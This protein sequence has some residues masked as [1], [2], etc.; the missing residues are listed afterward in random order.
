MPV[1]FSPA[2]KNSECT[3]NKAGPALPC[4]NQ[5]LGTQNLPG[6]ILKKAPPLYKQ[7]I[8]P[9]K[10]NPHQC[11]RV[12]SVVC[13][14]Q[15]VT[16]PNRSWSFH[17][18]QYAFFPLFSFFLILNTSLNSFLQLFCGWKSEKGEKNGKQTGYFSSIILKGNLPS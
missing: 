5:T 6:V 7:F 10:Q 18:L 15:K 14:V 12:E 1:T 11:Y 8:S 4:P 16:F 17:G 9:E 2:S 3:M 13:P